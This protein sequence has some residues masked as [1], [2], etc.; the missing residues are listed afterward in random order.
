MEQEETAISGEI[1]ELKH[2]VQ[3]YERTG[4]L[5]SEAEEDRSAKKKLNKLKDL[6]S[7]AQKHVEKAEELLREVIRD[8]EKEDQSIEDAILLSDGVRKIQEQEEE[9]EV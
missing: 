4:K 5:L 1:F 6:L 7:E 3:E 8:R 9:T 2:R